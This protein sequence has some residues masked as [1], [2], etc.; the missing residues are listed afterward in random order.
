[1]LTE[2]SIR[3]NN[4]RPLSVSSKI[5]LYLGTL[6]IQLRDFLNSSM[7]SHTLVILI[8]G[9]LKQ[10]DQEFMGKGWGNE[11]VGKDMCNTIMKM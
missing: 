8:C 5:R 7:I 1:M 3:D 6:A 4:I 10:E 11:S 9:K 2:I